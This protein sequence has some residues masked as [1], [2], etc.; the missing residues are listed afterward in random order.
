MYSYLSAWP[1]SQGVKVGPVSANRSLETANNM[2]ALY[3]ISP[4][5]IGNVEEF[6]QALEPLLKPNWVQVFQLRLKNIA[7]AE[8]KP[9]AKQL[10]RVCAD[11]ETVFLIN[12]DVKLAG[13]ICADGVHLGQSDMPY[14]Q[15]R[16]MLGPKSVIG[17]T[18]HNF[19]RLGIEAAAAGADYVAFGAFYPSAT[20]KPTTT[21]NRIY[22]NSGRPTA[23]HPASRLAELRLIRPL[24]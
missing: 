22:C 18:C 15:A 24:P 8:L 16:E 19:R 3:L 17:I 23:Q 2:A 1:F 14:D 21:R 13:E 7:R 6:A 12:D 11:T 10:K 4:P 20:K 9:I 5:S